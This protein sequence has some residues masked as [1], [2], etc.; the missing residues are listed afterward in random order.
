MDSM[1]SCDFGNCDYG[2]HFQDGAAV[3]DASLTDVLHE[4]FNN[5]NESSSEGKDFTL[6]NMMHWPRNTRLFSTEYPFPKDGVAFVDGS[7]EVAGTQVSR[8]FSSS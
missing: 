8:M 2:L 7:A 6:P 5:N 3:Q 4:V 1:Y